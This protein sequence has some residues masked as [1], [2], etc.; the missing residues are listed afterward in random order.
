MIK[1]NS[2]NRCKCHPH[3]VK[4]WHATAL[5]E[6]FTYDYINILI[7]R[8]HVPRSFLKSTEN[9]LVLMEEFGGDPLHISVETISL[10]NLCQPSFISNHYI[11]S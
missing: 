8:Y 9:V 2:K 6:T 11:P 3:V 1:I 4:I 10:T 5:K 7:C